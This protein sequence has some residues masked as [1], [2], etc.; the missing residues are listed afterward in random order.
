MTK[1]KL[2]FA[3]NWK[4]LLKV[5]TALFAVFYVAVFAGVWEDR[6]YTSNF[7]PNFFKWTRIAIGAAIVIGWCVLWFGGNKKRQ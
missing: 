5:V 4:D 7:W 1:I 2:W 6:N 3:E